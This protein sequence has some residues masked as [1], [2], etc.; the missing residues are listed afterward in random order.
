[1]KAIYLDCFSGISGN[2]FLGALLQ[3]GFSFDALRKEIAKLNLGKYELT[4]EDVTKCSIS[5]KYFDVKI[6]EN[7]PHER[8]LSQIEDIIKK[9]TLQEA[10]K[11]KAISIFRELAKAESE[12]HG[13]SMEEVH[14]HE[15]GAIDTIID[16]VGVL[17]ALD[18]LEIKKVYFGNVKTGYGFVECAH[19]T[20]PIP[21]PATASLLKGIPCE[22]G[23]VE[24]E[25][26]TPTGAVLLK[27]LG[28][29][30]EQPFVADKIAYGAGS[31]ELSIPNVVRLYMGECDNLESDTIIESS[32]NLDDET[33]EVI[34]YTVNRLLEKG[35]LDV[36]TE[37]VFMKKGRVGT[38]LSFLATS[39]T[40]KKLCEIVLQETS[41]LG[42]RF[43]KKERYILQRKII[44]KDTPF[45]KI[46]VKIAVR[47]DGKEK[48]APEYEDCHKLAEK[49]HVSLREI[50]NLFRFESGGFK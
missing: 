32:C 21:A 20:L 6:L 18:Y 19:G 39:D 48:L 12:V 36:W 44:E 15:V 45:G 23:K 16:I 10:V 43:V 9:S 33:G 50:Y 47:P 27:C 28:E 14:F 29:Y 25:L 7:H 3:M 38:K 46:K 11:T 40:H 1:M 49:F 2:M 30:C 26:L 24:G 42:L 4:Y 37:P 22:P 5:A 31:K 34:A 13:I 17:L 35:A 8:H 41:A